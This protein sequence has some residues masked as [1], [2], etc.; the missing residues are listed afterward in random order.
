MERSESN[1]LVALESRHP[2]WTSK[3]DAL[4]A[5][6]GGVLLAWQQ[7]QH[8]LV[9]GTFKDLDATLA[10]FRGPSSSAALPDFQGLYQ[11]PR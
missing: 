7:P 1:P 2:S 8:G 9:Y 3:C 5:E 11:V 4:A 10:A 6:P